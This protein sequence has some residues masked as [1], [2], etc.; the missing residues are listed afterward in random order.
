MTVL[1]SDIAR[2]YDKHVGDTSPSRACRSPSSAILAP[3]LTAPDQAASVP[4]AAAQQLFV[5]TLPPMIA[6]QA[7]PVGYRDL[8]G[9]LPDAGPGRRDARRRGSRPRCPASR[10]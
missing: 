8:D 4:L 7:H 1:G 10:R 5:K 2:K 6:A 9:R 3:T